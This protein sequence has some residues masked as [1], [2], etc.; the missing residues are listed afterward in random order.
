MSI[1]AEDAKD[2]GAKYYYAMI[3]AVLMLYTGFMSLSLLAFGLE[4]NGKIMA[5]TTTN[6]VLRKKWNATQKQ[7][8]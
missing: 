2:Q 6:E 4:T 8:T 7:I 5:N 1:F 3:T